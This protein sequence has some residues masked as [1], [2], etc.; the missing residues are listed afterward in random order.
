MQNDMQSN[1]IQEFLLAKSSQLSCMGF[2]QFEQLQKISWSHSQ[3]SRR[4]CLWGLG[5]ANKVPSTESHQRQGDSQKNLLPVDKAIAV[6]RVQA[7]KIILKV[8]T[9]VLVRWFF[10]PPNM[11]WQYMKSLHPCW[12]RARFAYLQWIIDGNCMFFWMPFYTWHTPMEHAPSALH[13]PGLSLG[14]EACSCSPCHVPR[15]LSAAGTF[16]SKIL[17]TARIVN[18][19]WPKKSSTSMAIAIALKNAWRLAKECRANL[20]WE[21]ATRSG[22]LEVCH[23]LQK[24]P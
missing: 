20:H 5:W 12:L 8:D 24:V 6:S 21:A 4:S 2:K 10:S 16:E 15:E 22:L 14:N 9:N 3:T 1:G 19:A 23:T 11:P 13:G 7:T 18:D 17:R